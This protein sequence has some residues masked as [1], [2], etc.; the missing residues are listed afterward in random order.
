[1]LNAVTVTSGS[2]SRTGAAG[3]SRGPA[4]ATTR[5]ICPYLIAD[6]GTW[7]RATASRD[8]RCTVVVPPAALAVDKQRRMCLVD[9]HRTCATYLAALAAAEG[10]ADARAGARATRWSLVRTAPVV[11]D[12]GRG[13]AEGAARRNGPQIALGGLMVLAFASVVLA[14]LGPAGP[15]LAGAVDTGHGSPSAAAT[16]A[17]QRPARAVA[18]PPGIAG[19]RSPAVE[20]SAAPIG[21]T[22]AAPVA[23]A[24]THRVVAGD[25][26]YALAIRFD[27]T[28]RALMKKNGLSSSELR[29]GRVLRIP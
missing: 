18:S 15:S 28:V 27:T 3:V 19:H 21:S 4:I 14:R 5:A 26:L 29:I 2:A 9:A 16:P 25:T 22:A 13:A 20:T 6:D 1:M 7:R 17:H 8:Q 12:R 23:P 11:L 24:R 10:D